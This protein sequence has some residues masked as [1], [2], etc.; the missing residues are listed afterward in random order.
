MCGILGSINCYF[1]E[2]ELNLIKHRGPDDFGLDE[3]SIGGNKVTLAQRRLSIIDVSPAGHQPMIS[4]C[5]NYAIIFNGEIY[6]H[7]DLR[8]SLSG[9]IAF[10]GHS[11]TESILYYLIQN[12]RNGL[13]DLNGI[14]ALAFLDIKNSTLLLARDPFGVKPLY[15]YK[16]ENNQII[17]SSEIRPI[18][19]LIG[20]TSLNKPALATLLR[21]RYN[22]APETL[23]EGIYKLQP[24]HLLEIEFSNDDFAYSHCSFIEKLSKPNKVKTD[25][26]VE[27]Y[28]I[29][30]EAAVKRQ[31]LSDVEVGILLSGGIDSA[32]VACLAQRHYKGK[33]KAFTIGFEGTHNEDEIADAAKTAEIL[34]LEHF[35]KKITFNDFLGLLKKCADIVEEPLATTS[36]IPMYYLSELAS[37][38][39]KVVLTGQGADEPLG[40]YTRYKLELIRNKFPAILLK[41][42]IPLTKNLKFSSEQLSRGIKAM[43]I[44][45]TIARFLTTYETFTADEIRNLIATEDKLSVKRISYYYDLLNCK[46]LKDS[47]EQMMAIDLHLNL[48]DDLLNYTDKIT[49]YHG[50]ECRVPMLDLELVKF[51]QSLP[52]KLKLNIRGGKIIH[53]KFAEQLLPGEIIQR[54]KKGFQSPTHLWFKQEKDSIKEILLSEDGLFAQLFNKR[55]VAKIINEHQSG[56]NR[57]KQIFL[58]L[59]IFYFLESYSKWLNE[60]KVLA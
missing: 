2:N 28:G 25:A 52:V 7:E 17:F 36:M 32:L 23:Y 29:A 1:N 56:V 47:V 8:N 18:K 54:K 26:M 20:N 11:D 49:M 16:E 35:Y 59:N 44:K 46:E 39:V 9:N 30:L 24:G 15:Y 41:T 27:K 12:G 60:S 21:L 5:G 38:K 40:G 48:A 13:K 37:E 19:Q 42:G 50:L 6:N 51:I 45:N 10:R 31:L 55:Y 4:S 34:G 33:L 57:E 43:G 14:F 22:P 3:F 58:L 53:K